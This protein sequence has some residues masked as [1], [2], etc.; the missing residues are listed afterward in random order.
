MEEQKPKQN[1]FPWK[2]R[3]LR[4]IIYLVVGFLC[5]FIYHQLKK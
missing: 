5:A 2:S 1:K 4:F 3:L